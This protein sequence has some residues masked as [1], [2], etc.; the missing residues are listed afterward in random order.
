MKVYRVLTDIGTLHVHCYWTEN[1]EQALEL[2]RA[3]TREGK[4]CSIRGLEVPLKKRQLVRWL[5]NNCRHY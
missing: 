3:H 5:N 2:R 1:R 4:L